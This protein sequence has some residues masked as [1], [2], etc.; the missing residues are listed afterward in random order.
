MSL[1]DRQTSDHA[2]SVLHVQSDSSSTFLE[3]EEHVYNV[4]IKPQ[5]QGVKSLS[6]TSASIP[7][8]WPAIDRHF[9][10]NSFILTLFN[11]AF[12][13]DYTIEFDNDDTQGIVTSSHL[14]TQLTTILN[15][16]TLGQ[17]ATWTISVDPDRVSLTIQVFPA[18]F[19]WRFKPWGN[20][21]NRK[22][23]VYE[24][25]GFSRKILTMVNQ[26]TH[27]GN[28]IDL[29][30]LHCI[31]IHID[32]VSN[33]VFCDGEKTTA[34]MLIPIVGSHSD[35]ERYSSQVFPKNVAFSQPSQFTLDNLFIRLT[36]P[37]GT[38]IPF[39][40]GRWTATF[41]VE[42]ISSAENLSA[43]PLQYIQ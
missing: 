4:Y 25:L 14:T 13:T 38:P 11:G 39:R 37:F 15:N 28:H 42:F 3:K 21:Q 6:L 20:S 41:S 35:I 2:I 5:F 9:Y 12:E 33:K 30:P 16:A 18:G 27:T 36:T 24:T 34:C 19:Q 43:H 26:N 22:N 32:Y 23:R 17:G 7:H 10:N 1:F 8:T 31:F 29:N 40:G